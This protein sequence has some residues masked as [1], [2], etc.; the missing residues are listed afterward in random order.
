MLKK[1]QQNYA[2][3][4]YLFWI[5]GPKYVPAQLVIGETERRDTKANSKTKALLI[6]A[7]PSPHSQTEILKEAMRRI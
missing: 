5:K 3:D 6:E 4:K 1:H 2:T 7:E